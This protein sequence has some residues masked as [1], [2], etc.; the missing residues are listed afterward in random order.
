MDG[1]R[2]GAVDEVRQQ[3]RSWESPWWLN[4]H[5]GQQNAGYRDRKRNVV[6]DARLLC[7]TEAALI[8]DYLRS[9]DGTD[10]RAR[11]AADAADAAAAARDVAPAVDSVPVNW[12]AA[13]ILSKGHFIVFM[14]RA[15]ISP[16]ILARPILSRLA[17]CVGLHGRAF[18][19]RK[20]SP[21]S[22]NRRLRNQNF[23]SWFWSR[24]TAR[25][26]EKL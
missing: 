23:V 16:S 5:V 20:S 1:E 13:D 10:R 4:R 6:P 22:S 26:D 21:L 14:T 2:S 7:C 8:I 9:H 15:E 18:S 12:C 25:R 24:G 11:A 19:E 3:P 17:F